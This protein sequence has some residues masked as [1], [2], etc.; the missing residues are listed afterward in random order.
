MVECKH[1]SML[2]WIFKPDTLTDK[3]LHSGIGGVIL[4]I[5]FKNV[6]GEVKTTPG[7]VSFICLLL[8]L[9]L[10]LPILVTNKQPKDGIVIRP[11]LLL[12]IAYAWIS[13]LYFFKWVKLVRLPAQ[14]AQY[15]AITDVFGTLFFICAWFMFSKHDPDREGR[16][17]ERTAF[18]V[19]TLITFGAGVSKTLIDMNIVGSGADDPA[20]RL[21]LNI[22]NALVVFSLYGQVRRLLPAPDPITHVLILLYGCAQIAAPARDCLYASSPC[23]LPS[24][25]AFVALAV[26]WS[27]LLG[28]IAFAVYVSYLY[29]NYDLSSK[30]YAQVALS[31]QAV[32]ASAEQTDPVVNHIIE[33]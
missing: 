19:L 28:K 29:F 17:A 15:D 24:L 20:A 27:L 30:E 13:L 10:L 6:I 25:Q 23:A 8:A 4:L 12:A 31:Q 2:S 26:D 9:L 3:I 5:L 21:I 33:E 11:A 22:C 32:S 14:Y 18:V 1:L 7:T 16:I